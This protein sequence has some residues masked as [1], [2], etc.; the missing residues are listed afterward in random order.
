MSNVKYQIFI[1]STYEDLKAER[2]QV[3]KAIL[4]MGHIPVGMEM[5]S[6]ADEDQWT[7]IA[8][9]IETCDYYVVIVAQRYGSTDASGRSFTEKEYDHA[10]AAGVPVLGFVL[11]DTANWPVARVDKDARKRK[12][13]DAFKEKVKSRYVSYWSSADDLYGRV[14]VAVTK[15]MAVRPRTGWIRADQGVSADVAAEL[16]RLSK[17]N[18]ELRASLGKV[19]PAAAHAPDAAAAWREFL[20]VLSRYDGLYVWDDRQKDERYKV[21]NQALSQLDLDAIGTATEPFLA[22]ASQLAGVILKEETLGAKLAEF[23]Q[24][25]ARALRQ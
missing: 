9:H 14:S 11:A 21:I 15:Q 16:A 23:R 4:E 7:I 20:A 12:A 2:D 3:A 8:R 22:E 1:S 6:A 10:I 13:L 17:E 5:F 25:V 24:R 19:N 18:A